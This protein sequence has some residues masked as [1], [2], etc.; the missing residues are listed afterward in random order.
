MTTPTRAQD[1]TASRGAAPAGSYWLTS[2]ADTTP[3]PPLRPGARVDIAVVG[4]GIVGVTCALLLARGGARVALLEADELGAGTTGATTAKVT[5]AHGLVYDRL[6]RR[7]GADRAGAYGHA[8]EA[9]L[10]WMA[11]LVRD[12]DLDCDWRARDAYTYTEDERR[13]GTIEREAA[14]A[15]ELGLPAEFTTTVPGPPAARAAVRMRDQAEMHPRRYVLALADLAEAA[16]CLIAERTRVTG[17]HATSPCVVVQTDRATLEADRVVIATQFPI[18]DRSL[19]FA[20]MHTSRSYIVGIRTPRP[21]PAMLYG[22]D[23]PSR[24]VRSAPLPD[25]AE[26][27]MIGGE[28]HPTGGDTDTEARYR[29]LA[30][31]ARAWFG[32]API[33]HRWSSQDMTSVDDLPYAEP[34]LASGGRVWTVTGLRKWGMTLGTAAAHHLAARFEDRDSPHAA[35]FDHPRVPSLPAVGEALRENAGNGWRLATG[36]LRRGPVPEDLAAGEG[37][38][39]GPPHRRVAAYRD[40]AGAL[41]R[42]S[43]TC[44]HLGCEVRFNPAERSWDCPC[45]A[46]RFDARDGRVLDGPAVHRLPPVDR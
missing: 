6:T 17:L 16:G 46:S 38:V 15:R 3:R 43:A 19:H 21:A 33:T 18:L 37:A 31:T 14:V 41:H 4:G 34:V 26:L 1:R 23:D 40:D 20:R 36:R 24:S 11:A 29:A 13:V 35:A 45:H 10:A 9:A 39:H 44:T 42:L 22:I 8:N 2:T 25:G 7:V 5:S 28:G 12:E 32:E 27:M 30:D